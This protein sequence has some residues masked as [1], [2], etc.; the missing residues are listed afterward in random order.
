MY[1]M[2]CVVVTIGCLPNIGFSLPGHRGGL[3]C[4]ALLWWMAPFD[5]VLANE[6]G[7]QV[8]RILKANRNPWIPLFPMAQ[9][10]GHQPW[11]RGWLCQPR[12]LND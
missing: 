12:F 3:G 2:V 1:G 8:T 6:L 4:L 5:R 9:H 11:W 7:V 10:P